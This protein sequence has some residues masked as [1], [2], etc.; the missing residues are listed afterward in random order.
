VALAGI[1]D[2]GSCSVA[3]CEGAILEIADSLIGF[4]RP[5]GVVRIVRRRRRFTPAFDQVVSDRRVS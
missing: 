1:K 2:P 3:V 4:E 5:N